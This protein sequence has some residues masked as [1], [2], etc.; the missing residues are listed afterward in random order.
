MLRADRPD[1]ALLDRLSDDEK[2]VWRL[3]ADGAETA[4]VSRR[5]CV[6]DRTAKR[7]VAGVLRKIGATN[8]TQAA[9]LAIRA[10]L[11]DDAR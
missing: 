5:C 7:L 2:A 1:E 6:S 9:V 3:L 10:G 8:R 4:E 11:L